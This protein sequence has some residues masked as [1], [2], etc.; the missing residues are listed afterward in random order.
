MREEAALHH[1]RALQACL[2]CQRVIPLELV[3]AVQPPL[4]VSKAKDLLCEAVQWII[5]VSGGG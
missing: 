3:E 2:L 5:T 1:I 4:P